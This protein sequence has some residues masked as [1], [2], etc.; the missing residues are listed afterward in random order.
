MNLTPTRQN[1]I[2]QNFMALEGFAKRLVM[3]AKQGR[4][5]ILLHVSNS[6]EMAKVSLQHCQDCINEIRRIWGD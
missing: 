1:H 5:E 4:D 3:F 6:E 2:E